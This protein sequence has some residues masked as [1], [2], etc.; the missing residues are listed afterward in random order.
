MKSKRNLLLVSSIFTSPLILLPSAQAAI[1][2]WSGL[3][4]DTWSTAA[5]NWSFSPAQADPWDI[6]NGPGNI[7]VFNLAS[8]AAPVSGTVHTNGI[9]F[10]TTGTINAGGIITLAGTSPV[11]SA[12]SGVTGTFKSNLA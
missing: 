12:A 5:T 8:L 2:S 9:T 10:N 4:G 6:T 11:L 7:A 3:V 1:G